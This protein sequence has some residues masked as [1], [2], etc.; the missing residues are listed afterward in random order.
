MSMERLV[1]RD[2]VRRNIMKQASLNEEI[3]CKPSRTFGNFR[4]TLYSGNATKRFQLIKSGLTNRIKQSTTSMEKVSSMAL[5]NGF[6]KILQ[7]WKS[8]ENNVDTTDSDVDES[9]QCNEITST[10][11][12]G[13]TVQANGVAVATIIPVS[14]AGVTKPEGETIERRLSKEDGSD[15]SKDSSL[16]SDTSVDSEDSFASVI[17]VP[18]QQQHH[19]YQH[20]Q[21]SHQLHYEHQFPSLIDVAT[22]PV[23]S[24]QLRTTSAPPSPRI[25]HPPEIHGPRLKLISISPLLKQF[26]ATSKSLPPPSPPGLSPRNF[27]VFGSPS[28]FPSM[29]STDN[30]TFVNS[31]QNQS[32]KFEATDKI[33]TDVN[34]NENRG[35]DDPSDPTKLFDAHCTGE[36]STKNDTALCQYQTNETIEGSVSGDADDTGIDEATS[37]RCSLIVKNVIEQENKKISASTDIVDGPKCK[38]HNNPLSLHP[39]QRANDDADPDVNAT[40][41]SADFCTAT[42]SDIGDN[43]SEKSKSESSESISEEDSRG[44]RLKQI[45]E[46]LKQ[47]PGFATRCGKSSFPLV[48]RASTVTSGR[49]EM[50]DARTLPR[51]LSLELF[52]PETDDLDSD[53]SGLSSPESVGSVISVISDERFTLKNKGLSREDDLVLSLTILFILFHKN[54]WVGLV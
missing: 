7:G 16:Q 13:T 6:V 15:S 1:E 23:G 33:N 9:K 51:L 31:T 34:M 10:R 12:T 27:N 21:N 3:I 32:V 35:E 39:V 40:V 4:D 29:N 17:Y 28:N 49:S 14:P 52:N 30:T 42:G 24:Y 37:R 53:S 11:K 25:K 19:N 44:S 22:V 45:K 5:K 46:L 43:Q 2:R 20:H 54:R 26:P 36:K 48:R 38:S 8:G 47:K 50:V 41:L 18:K